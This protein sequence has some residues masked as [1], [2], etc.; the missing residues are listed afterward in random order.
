MNPFEDLHGVTEELTAIRCLLVTD[1][2]ATIRDELADHPVQD[3][4]DL[5]ERLDLPSRVRVF[6]ALEQE[7]A[8]EVFSYLEP[9][10]VAELTSELPED[11][12]RHLLA[13]LDPDDRA[14]LFLA[15]P[16][17]LGARLRGLLSRE[18]ADEL[19]RL[20]D[21]PEDSVGRRMNPDVVVV[22][23]GWTVAKA[24]DHIR[25]FEEREDA[26]T[27]VH[28]VDARGVLQDAL[29]LRHFVFAEPQ[30]LVRD[31]MQ[32]QPCV[33]IRADADQEEAVRMIRHYDLLSLPVVNE[34]GVLLGLVSIDDVMDMAEEE[35]TE[36]FHKLGSVGAVPGGMRDATMGLLFR[37]R[38]GS[39][40]VLV[41]MSAGTVFAMS[42]FE[43]TLASA[44]A[45]MFFLPLLIDSSGNAGSQ[46]ATLMVRALATGDVEARDW[47]RLLGRE[48]LVASMLGAVMALGAATLAWWRSPEVLWIVAVTMFLTVITGGLL[49]ILLPTLLSRC[50]L[51]PATASVPLITSLADVSGVV[52]Y[53]S[54][55]S[56]WLG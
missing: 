33:R 54:I 29:R 16:S 28:V 31:I 17:A 39:L 47:L 43:E 25:S 23:A 18:D 49:G 40:L 36:D 14:A 4:A 5:L 56:V 48:L 34:H 19:A 9:D 51:D 45:L 15:L 7:R 52:I 3:I 35:Y 26:V 2:P 50:R 6:S 10:A 46:A 32:E 42:H 13:A 1:D 12:V 55:A 8:D 38:V 44:L 20:L 30:T 11:Q 27:V 24:L 21:F 37:Q 22:R 41:L 53:F